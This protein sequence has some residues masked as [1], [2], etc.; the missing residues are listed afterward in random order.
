MISY[1]DINLNACGCPRTNLYTMIQKKWKKA[2]T[3]GKN[4][5][6]V[7]ALTFFYNFE[8]LNLWAY[9]VYKIPECQ[10]PLCFLV[11]TIP[12]FNVI[13]VWINWIKSDIMRYSC[14]NFTS[15][16]R[17][18]SHQNRALSFKRKSWYIL[19]GYVKWLR[20]VATII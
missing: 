15:K 8:S 13:K 4:W 7:Q 17:D 9:I 19:K 2:P 5:K 16:P 12:S 1:V 11:L 6:L 3:L 20:H 10:S 18:I 14:A